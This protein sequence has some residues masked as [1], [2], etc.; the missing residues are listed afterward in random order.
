MMRKIAKDEDEEVTAEGACDEGERKNGRGSDV[1]WFN[2]VASGAAWDRDVRAAPDRC[3]APR[4]RWPLYRRR[5]CGFNSRA[6]AYAIPTPG[7][8]VEQLP[9]CSSWSESGAVQMSR[10]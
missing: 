5:C 2:D 4:R 1:K 7:R 3:R 8:R 10:G 6:V 9:G